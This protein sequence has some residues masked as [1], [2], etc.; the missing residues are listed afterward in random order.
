MADRLGWSRTAFDLPNAQVFLSGCS[1]VPDHRR[2]RFLAHALGYHD[3]RYHFRARRVDCCP[4][5]VHFNPGCFRCRHAYLVR[6]GR[7]RDRRLCR[8]HFWQVHA[9]RKSSCIC[10]AGRCGRG[11]PVSVVRH[12]HRID[13]AGTT[14]SSLAAPHW[15]PYSVSGN[16]LD[17]STGALGSTCQA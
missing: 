1:L 8:G 13:F 17:V 12:W 6:N 9:H 14:R 16:P 4:V 3:A 7:R 15:S 5:C 10:S 2:T 11:G